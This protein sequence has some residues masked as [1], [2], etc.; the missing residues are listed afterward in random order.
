MGPMALVVGVGYGDDGGMSK[1]ITVGYDGS[2]SSSEAVAWAA[3]EAAARGSRLRIVTCY[4]IPVMGDA[5]YWPTGDVYALLLDGAE[6]SVSAMRA[7]VAEQHPGLEIVTDASAGPATSV[8]LHDVEP[9]DL[10]VVGASSHEGASAFWLGS[11]PRQVVRQSPCPVVVVRGAASRGRPDRVVVAVDGSPSS[12]LALRWAADE[13]DLHGVQLVVLHA[14]EYPYLPVDA[15]S[16]QGHDITKID[17]ACLL[18]R[19]TEAA[20]ERCAADVIDVLVEDT[21]VSALLETVRDGDLVVV[22]SRGRGAVRAG[23]FGSTVN[24]VLEQSAVPVV[25]VRGTPAD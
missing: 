16:A 22:G 9:E 19:A 13:A 17:A 3:G 4:A 8:L 10:V 6:K 18:D 2:P 15:G 7:I 14:W 12:D 24:S 25:V 23:L 11:T 5:A 1:Q 21:P 20:R